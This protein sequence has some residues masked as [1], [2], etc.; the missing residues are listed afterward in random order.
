MNNENNGFTRS[1]GS[2]VYD[3]QNSITTNG[4]EFTIMSDAHLFEKM[5]HFN[6]E[7]IP[8]RIVHA[9]GAGAFGVFTLTRDMS[10]YTDADIFFCVGKHTE[11]LARFS[12]VGG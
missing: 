5:A 10:E 4:N 6:R 7:R 3:D 2:R 1:T 9:K 11:M 8:E 12:T